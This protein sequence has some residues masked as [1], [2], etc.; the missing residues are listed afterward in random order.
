MEKPTGDVNQEYIFEGREHQY[1]TL[2][3]IS[4]H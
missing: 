4:F 1:E 3:H 2:C